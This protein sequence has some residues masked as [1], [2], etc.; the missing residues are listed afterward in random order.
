MKTTSSDKNIKGRRFGNIKV[1]SVSDKK[2]YAHGTCWDCRCDCG[3]LLLCWGTRLRIGKQTHCGCRT[4]EIIS[5][6][7]TTHG[8]SRTH[9]YRTLT[10]MISR[11]E[12]SSHESFNDY[13]GRGIKVCREWRQ[14]PE[15]FVHWALANGY[16]KGLTIDRKNNN[17]PYSPKNCRWVGWV[18]QARNRRSNHVVTWRGQKKTIAEWAEIT[19]L[20]YHTISKRI[21]KYK[22]SVNEALSDA[23]DRNAWRRGCRKQ[24]EMR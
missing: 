24:Q 16:R 20:K 17:G 5:K 10:R 8:F 22:W 21:I 15:V 2:L 1:I 3:K 11:C 13:G 6:G 12:R 9:V 4:S 7:R 19:G 18:I 14:H 23:P